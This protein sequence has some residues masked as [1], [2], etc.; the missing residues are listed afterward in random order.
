MPGIHMRK[1]ESWGEFLRTAREFLGRPPLVSTL[2]A[3]DSA[4]REKVILSVSIGNNCGVC[5]NAHSALAHTLGIPPG[6]VEN[7]IRL[8][9][10]CFGHRE[11]VALSYARQWALGRGKDPGGEISRQYHSEFTELERRHLD[12]ILR[13]MK[14]ANYTS[15]TLFGIPWR[16]DLDTG[17]LPEK[18]GWGPFSMVRE[19]VEGVLHD[20][21]LLSRR[22]VGKVVQKGVSACQSF[23]GAPVCVPCAT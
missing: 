7:L 10:A 21:V 12:K 18:R 2:L 8:D 9:P 3:V 4:F 15:N 1:F 19:P 23:L 14:L 11:W 5:A 13:M 20:V 16:E 17:S 22:R 6:E